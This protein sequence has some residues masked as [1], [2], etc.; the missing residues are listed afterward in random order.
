MAV[1]VG[2]STFGPGL[3][4]LLAELDMVA[5]MSGPAAHLLL[6]P[7][8]ALCRCETTIVEQIIVLATQH[9]PWL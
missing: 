9:R 2:P 7:R 4:Q 1:A 8:A 6:A 3:I 5:G